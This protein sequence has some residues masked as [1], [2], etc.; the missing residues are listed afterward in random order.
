M[1]RPIDRWAAL[2][3]ALAVPLGCGGD[4]DGPDAGPAD[5]TAPRDTGPAADTGPAEDTGPGSDTTA[6]TLTLIPADGATVGDATVALT[7]SYT[8][9]DSG[10]D[11]ATV[12]A[13][14]DGADV[15]AMLTVDGAMATMSTQL[16]AGMHTFAVRV[17]DGAGNEASASSTF[18]VSLDADPPTITIEVPA[19]AGPS[20]VLTVRYSDPDSGVDPGTLAADI[21]GVDVSAMLTAGAA[22]ATLTLG[23]LGPEGAVTVSATVA[24]AAGNQAF[25]SESFTIDRSGPSITLIPDGV[26]VPLQMPV[27]LTASYVD[28][29]C[30][31][32]DLGRFS[33]E[34]DGTSITG[35]F[36][37]GAAQATAMVPPVTSGQHMWTVTAVDALGNSTVTSAMFEAG[38]PP[39]G[40]VLELAPAMAADVP[41]GA[42]QTLTVRA[43]SMSGFTASSFTG[44]VALSASDGDEQLDGALLIFGPADLGEKTLPLRFQRLG[45][46][47]IAADALAAP[48]LDF[49]TTLAVEVTIAAPIFAPEP[50]A[51]TATDGALDLF[52]FSF[53]GEPVSLLVDGAVFATVPADVDGAFALSVTLPPGVHTVLAQARGIDSAMYTVTVPDPIVTALRVDPSRLDLAVGQSRRLRAVA[54]LDNGTEAIVTATATWST[55]NTAVTV[56]PDGMITADAEGSDTVTA[57]FGGQMAT[58]DVTVAAP[59]LELTSPVHGEEGVAVTRETVLYFSAPLDPVSV[60]ADA[61]FATFGGETLQAE[62]HLTADRRRVFMFYAE[63]LPA[64][65]RIRVTVHGDRLQTASA[66][67]IDADLDGVA[68]G[69]AIIDFDTLSLTVVEGTAVTGRIFASELVRT[70]TAAGQWLNLPLGGVHIT[71]DGSTLAATSDARGNFRLEPAP[72]GR[73][74]VHIDGATSTATVPPGAYY[75]TVGKAWS[76]IAGEETNVGNVHLPLIDPNALQATGAADTMIRYSS[77]ILAGTTIL[78]PGGSLVGDNCTNGTGMVGAAPVDPERLPGTL[79]NGLDLALVITLQSDCA[80]NFDAPVPVCLPNTE[81]LPAG[82]ETA[83]WSFNHDSGTWEV[84]GGMTVSDDGT[85]VCTDPGV[86]I[87]A[88]GWHGSQSGTQGNGGGTRNGDPNDPSRGGSGDQECTSGGECDCDGQCSTSNSVLLH[89]GEERLSRVDLFIP[90]RGGINFQLSRTY[91][92]RLDYDGPL[93]HGWSFSYDDVLFREPNG[94]ITSQNGR[95]KI[96]TWTREADQSLRSPLGYFQNMRERPD[97]SI[98]IRA[99][100]GSKKLYGPDG[101]LHARYDRHGNTMLFYYDEAGNLDIIVDPYGREIDFEFEDVAGRDRLVRVTDFAGRQIEYSYDTRGD[102]VAVRSPVITGTPHGNDFP[103]GRT[104]RYEYLFGFTGGNEALNHNLISVTRPEEVANGGPRRFSGPTAGTPTSR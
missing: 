4:D 96:D 49:F 54:T 33:A 1:S 76:S 20:S 79:P 75:P 62:L 56:A 61:I 37:I 15:T 46:V 71:V 86:G 36:T 35:D 92:S 5:A 64:S 32:V 48:P 93:G 53:P 78:V 42:P 77:G 12:S 26:S 40:L 51:T 47:L 6:P 95:S 24:D 99:P 72:A 10:I 103:D 83:L 34:L 23:A 38:A 22:E 43:V 84:V 3:L 70:G 104:E 98:V 65:A 50:A 25:A 21:G 2:L 88:P 100:D 27:D 85:Q 59:I 19:C 94:D 31:A 89:S 60:T 11:Q 28:V 55:T 41:L 69:D 90:G 30:S 39:L 101:R 87:R 14:L 82:A 29:G 66:G 18:T 73:F 58:T 7:A 63:P 67:A 102:L 16:A 97:G 45:E 80:S 44:T 74:F 57:M 81:G 68:G 8:D 52:G 17:S 91:R 9:A 13:T